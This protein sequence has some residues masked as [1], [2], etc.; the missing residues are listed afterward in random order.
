V[1]PSTKGEGRERRYFYGSVWAVCLAQP[2]L[3]FLWKALPQTPA[4]DVVKL[5]AFWAIMGLAAYLS[6]RGRL[7]RTRPILPGEVAVSD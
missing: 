4:A 2:A 5:T 6:I 1:R 7:P 3:L